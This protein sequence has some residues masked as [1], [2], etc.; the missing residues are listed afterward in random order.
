MMESFSLKRKIVQIAFDSSSMAYAL[1]ND[2]SVW[3]WIW[4]SE[5]GGGRWQE[6]W[7]ELPNIEFSKMR[8]STQE[9]G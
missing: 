5:G 2:G 8:G 4:D 9:E 1:A 6:Q 3:A 7:M